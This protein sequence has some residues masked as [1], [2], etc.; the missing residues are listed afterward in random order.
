[1][2]ISTHGIPPSNITAM[3]WLMAWQFV[4]SYGTFR[5][6]AF[7]RFD[8][9]DFSSLD[10]E[11]M[12]QKVVHILPVRLFATLRRYTPWVKKHALYIRS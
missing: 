3:F 8:D 2:H 10:I 6:W 12:L 1:M 5:A 4:N 11:I 7:L 9:L